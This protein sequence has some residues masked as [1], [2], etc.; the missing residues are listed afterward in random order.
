[1]VFSS[2]R[3]LCQHWEQDSNPWPRN[4]HWRE[5]ISTIDLL[6]LT[7]LVKHHFPFI[8]KTYYL[9]FTK[10][11]L[12]T[13]RSSVLSLPILVRIPCLDLRQAFYRCVTGTITLSITTISIMS[14]STTINKWDTRHNKARHNGRVLLCW[15]LHIS[16]SYWVL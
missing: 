16:L 8:L 15:V 14:F 11:T 6:G 1:M 9:L 13:R 5:R 3:F 2:I 10:Q 7:S 12:P 4:P